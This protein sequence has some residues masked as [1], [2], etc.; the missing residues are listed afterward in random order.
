MKPV[1]LLVAPAALLGALAAAPG[2]AQGSGYLSANLL[3]SGYADGGSATGDAGADF[4]GEAN[5]TRGRLC[6][7]LDI[8]GIE[9]IT[10]AHIH[11]GGADGPVA[12]T[13]ATPKE[14]AG[15]VCMDLDKALLTAMAG[16]PGGY[17]IDIHTA[18]HPDGAVRGTLSD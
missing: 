10:E 11:E 5:L 18:A 1:S 3:G 12:V 4:N 14:G 8:F 9:G 13:L 15:E 7:Y 17:S 6:Y 2:A 16:N